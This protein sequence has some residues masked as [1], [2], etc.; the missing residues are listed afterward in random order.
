MTTATPDVAM[1][2]IMRATPARRDQP[3]WR[4]I[5]FRDDDVTE[6]SPRLDYAGALAWAADR[7]A[8]IT[9]DEHAEQARLSDALD[10]CQ[11]SATDKRPNP[12]SCGTCE[13]SKPSGAKQQTDGD[14]C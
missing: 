13:T 6:I 4:C 10:R 1:A 11:E 2:A 14:H 3:D 7:G 8:A 5:V 9:F 12:E